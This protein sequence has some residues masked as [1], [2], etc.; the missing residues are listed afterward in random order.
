MVLEVNPATGEVTQ[1]SMGKSTGNNILDDASLSA[2][3]H[4]HLQKGGPRHVQTPIIFTMTGARVQTEYEE[5]SKNMDDVLAR[6]L[7]RARC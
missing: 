4:G 6:S 7:E 3:R 1:A 2:V 5:E